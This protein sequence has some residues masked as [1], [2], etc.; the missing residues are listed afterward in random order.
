M[1]T[2]E[3]Y[4]YALENPK[5]KFRSLGEGMDCGKVYKSSGDILTLDIRNGVG[6][7]VPRIDGEWELVREPVDFMTAVRAYADGKTITCE[8]DTSD[9]TYKP[10]LLT[11]MRD[12]FGDPV[13]IS[14]MLKGKWYIKD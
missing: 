3:M 14:E 1:K 7:C 9:H 2:W 8:F 10:S 5:A 13:T 4:K 12:Q 11:H 6:L